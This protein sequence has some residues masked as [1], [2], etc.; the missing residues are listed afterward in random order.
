MSALIAPSTHL[1]SLFDLAAPTGRP[2]NSIKNHWNSKAMQAKYAKFNANP[3]KDYKAKRTQG[4]TKKGLFTKLLSK[5][6]S[7]RK[8]TLVSVLSVLVFRFLSFCSHLPV[9]RYGYT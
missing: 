8:L 9:L 3:R 7:N 1:C 6:K 4:K 5:V 2:D